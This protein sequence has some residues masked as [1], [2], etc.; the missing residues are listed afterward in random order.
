MSVKSVL[1]REH[2]SSNRSTAPA[3]NIWIPSQGRHCA[4]HEAR[5]L[6][7]PHLQGVRQRAA[8]D[9]LL[10]ELGPHEP[11]PH[12]DDGDTV[13]AYWKAVAA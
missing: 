9:G 7:R 4:P 10:N 11:G 3:V 12:R 5:R 13:R 1:V 8:G 2:A 6:R